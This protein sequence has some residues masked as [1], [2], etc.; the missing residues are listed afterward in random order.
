MGPIRTLYCQGGS[1]ATKQKRE[2]LVGRA[3]KE[4][5]RSDGDHLK[6]NMTLIIFLAP[7]KQNINAEY[8]KAQL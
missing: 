7:T 2:D 3:T 1:A 4:T 5:T 6:D 8:K